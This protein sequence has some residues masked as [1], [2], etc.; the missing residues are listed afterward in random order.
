MIVLALVVGV[1][2]VAR[3]TRLVVLDRV[4]VGLR[5]RVVNKWGEDSA[6]SYFIHCPWCVS[7]WVAP[8]VMVVA[9]LFP[10][11]WVVGLLAIPAASHI[12]GLLANL[13]E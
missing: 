11:P 6:Q 3:L 2:A 10:Y 1:L 9:A 13:E 8:P 12:T 7:M 5:R 4:T